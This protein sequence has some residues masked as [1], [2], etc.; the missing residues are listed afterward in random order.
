DAVVIGT[1]LPVAMITFFA[2]A[3]NL[4]ES[5]RS[6]VGGIS[7]T[8]APRVSA[9]QGGGASQ[10]AGRVAVTSARL[11][12]LVLL[13]IVLTFIVRGSAFV[14]VWMGPSY[15]DRSGKVLFVLALLLG[16][17]AGKQVIASALLGLNQH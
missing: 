10:D 4:T 1:F 5:G 14:G 17:T 8:V 7:Q 3:A 12:T 9:L 2:I 15:T 16:V 13:P 6:L 11:A